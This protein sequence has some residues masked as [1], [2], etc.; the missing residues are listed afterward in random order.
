MVISCSNGAVQLLQVLPS[1]LE[2]LHIWK[3]HQ[4]EAWI[5][6]FDVAKET[7]YSGGDDMLFKGWDPRQPDAILINK[8]HDAG[9]CSIAGHPFLEHVLATGSYDE[10]IRLWDT[11]SLKRPVY[12][13][14]TGGGV[15][16]LKWHPKQNLLLTACMYNGFH[17]YNVL[18][19]GFKLDH[20]LAYTKHESIAYGADWSR[21]EDWIGTCSFYD[22][23][24]RLWKLDDNV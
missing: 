15:W 22:H 4:Y 16:R 7:L 2:S 20:Y 11:R 8:Q 1:G 17:V 6:C 14:H 24:F 21:H 3:A 13:E 5:T 12:Q 18:D 9:V 19:D 23:S 10:Y